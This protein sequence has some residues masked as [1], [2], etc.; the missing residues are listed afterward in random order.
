MMRKA[1]IATIILFI[2]A[3]ALFAL[4]GNVKWDW[5]ENDPEV[6]YYR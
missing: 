1:L 2:S 6:E 5:F 4:D 3:F